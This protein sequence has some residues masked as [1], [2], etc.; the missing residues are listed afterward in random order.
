MIS[1]KNIRSKV[2]KLFSED[3]QMK[4]VLKISNIFWFFRKYFLAVEINY[5]NEFLEN[6]EK[7]K[8]KAD[9]G[10]APIL[11][12]EDLETASSVVRD[13]LTPDVEKIII[14]SL[15]QKNLRYS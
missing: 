9:T 11:V 15:P 7:I 1:F 10:A 5:E 8:T 14:D 13:L 3:Q 6:W 2:S 4:I 12:Y